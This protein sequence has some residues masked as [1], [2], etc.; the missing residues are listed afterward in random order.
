VGLAQARPNY[1]I[2]SNQRSVKEQIVFN[3]FKF[4]RDIEEGQ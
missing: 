3:F 4:L 1:E 2:G